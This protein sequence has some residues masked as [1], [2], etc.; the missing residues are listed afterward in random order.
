MLQIQW[1]G[2][3][4]NGLVAWAIGALLLSSAALAQAPRPF[5]ISGGG[6]APNGLQTVPGA[7]NARPHWAIGQATHLGRHI[8]SGTLKL[9]TVEPVFV[10]NQL[11]GFQ[12]KFGSARPF[13]F[14]AAN[15]DKLVT[16]Y[17]NTDFGAK[18]AGT[19]EITILG[20]TPAG[21]LMS[22]PFSSRNSSFNPKNLRGVSR[23]RLDPGSWTRA[24]HPLSSDPPIRSLTIGKDKEP[25]SYRED[26]CMMRCRLV[27]EVMSLSR[28]TLSVAAPL[29][30]DLRRG[31][32]AASSAKGEGRRDQENERLNMSM[33]RSW[34]LN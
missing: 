4:R 16:Y 28:V 14:N 17:G 34:H 25:S 23:V 7:E 10:G 30:P 5:R 22:R 19:Y 20:A 29:T 8:G 11:V 15:G 21:E 27:H 1:A 12:G 2:Y 6:A 13:V 9:D 33:H 26:S 31:G 24:L 18:E 3:M 32:L